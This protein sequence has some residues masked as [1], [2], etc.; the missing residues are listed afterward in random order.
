MFTD[1]IVDFIEKNIDDKPSILI[2][3]IFD[4]FGEEFT[5]RQISNK[6][7][8]LR[9]NSKRKLDA[10]TEIKIDLE[11]STKNKEL[12]ESKG[13]DV[14]KF[15][16]T[17][18]W[19]K[20]K[21][22]S[23][24]IKPKEEALTREELKDILS[25]NTNTIQLKTAK[26]QG[27]TNYCINF[28][29]M[30]F[31]ITKLKDIS[32][33]LQNISNYFDGKSAKEIH[34]NLLGDEFHTAVIG[35]SVTESITLLNKTYGR[36]AMRDFRDFFYNLFEILSPAC[37]KIHVHRCHGNHDGG[38]SWTCL[39]W[40]QEQYPDVE[41][42]LD[43]DDV[44]SKDQDY[45]LV[46]N[47]G[48][49]LTH[50]DKGKGRWEGAF[51]REARNIFRKAN[52]IYILTGHLHSEKVVETNFGTKIYQVGTNK[53]LDNWSNKNLFLGS[54]TERNWSIFKLSENEIKGIE[55]V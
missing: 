32:E 5:S 7:D 43:F 14:D 50:G 42:H 19:V 2:D 8:Y 35:K 4:K 17:G 6:K 53:S 28:A 16:V 12:L 24:H 36:E 21:E 29:D 51:F 41:F 31:G 38:L 44:L 34:I 30:H 23:I 54:L 37:S 18:A 13:F 10:S 39:F 55:Y 1:K 49:M 27:H 33:S 22:L 26:K 48:F 9:K 3:K 52:M 11:E 20:N 25:E 46:D 40:L 47:V 45:Y 15:E